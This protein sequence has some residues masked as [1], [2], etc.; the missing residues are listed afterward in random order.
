MADAQSPPPLPTFAPDEKVCG[1]CKLWHPYEVDHRGWVGPCRVQPQRGLFPGTAPICDA[2][3][4]RGVPTPEAKRDTSTT[5][6]RP[7]PVRSVAPV[8]L[9]QGEPAPRPATVRPPAA[10]ASPPTPRRDPNEVVDLGLGGE[11]N[12][13]RDELMELFREAS[14]ET[15]E[16]PPM[17]AKWQGGVVQILPGNKE[18][19]GKELPIDSLFHKVVMIRDRL[20]TLEQKINGHPKLTDAEK[21]EIQHYVTR[22]YG[23]LTSFNLLFRDKDD[24]FT[25]QKGED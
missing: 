3:A 1:H 12:M 13:T 19:Q 2:F 11:L 20:R 9:R 22:V 6:T 18:L 4:R 15:A 8:V 24:Q 5:T 16:P 25:G 21:V 23:S 10:P 14:G 7:R 17:A